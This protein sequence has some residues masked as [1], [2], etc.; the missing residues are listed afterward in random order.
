[1]TGP[2]VA[3]YAQEKE[4][5]QYTH[6]QLLDCTPKQMGE[7][8][9]KLLNEI[10]QAKKNIQS[11]EQNQIANAIKTGRELSGH[12]VFGYCIDITTI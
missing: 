5:E 11:L 12:D 9:Q 2:K 6:A 4:Q 7:K 1:M 8:I 3:F 10:E